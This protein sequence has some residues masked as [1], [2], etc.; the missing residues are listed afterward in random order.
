VEGFK[1]IVKK[2]LIN[3]LLEVIVVNKDTLIE[4][5]IKIIIYICF[6]F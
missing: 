2:F 3:I 6:Y 1:E 5:V 4:E